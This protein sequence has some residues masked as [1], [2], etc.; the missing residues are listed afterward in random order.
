M[1]FTVQTDI[2]PKDIKK[3]KKKRVPREP[4]P[5]FYAPDKYEYEIGIDEAGRGP[6][7]GRLY[8]AAVV[9]PKDGS[10]NTQ[11]I[12]DSKKISKKHLPCL[13][14][15]IKQHALAY[16]IHY[17]DAS[18]IDRINIREAVVKAM[19]IC[20][21][22]VIAQLE[23][24]MITQSNVNIDVDVDVDM[25]TNP[26]F[27][28]HIVSENGESKEKY[29]LMV[30]GND[31]P[32]Y[33]HISG[34][35]R[36]TTISSCRSERS[37]PPLPVPEFLRDDDYSPKDSDSSN[38][39]TRISYQ[40]FLQGDNSYANIAAASILAKVSRDNYVVALCKKYPIL[41]THYSMHE[42][43]GY[44]TKK[45]LEAI[46]NYGITQFHRRT[47]GRCKDARLNIV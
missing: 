21:E 31:F 42:H 16:Y 41:A 22:K 9:L 33:H 2:L 40:T 4:L 1:E 14:D 43:M 19:H 35:E 37:E 46:Q 20:A 15:Y 44:G 23:S 8:V 29:L 7:F 5:M 28:T 12:R 3:E 30:D 18:E 47:Y 39:G 25:E 38:M 45:H 32:P 26:D 13:Y 10:M 11:D 17:I 27:Q 6:L 34:R 36:S 24:K